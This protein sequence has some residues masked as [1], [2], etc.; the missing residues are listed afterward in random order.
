MA[1]ELIQGVPAGVVGRQSSG[2]QGG[3]FQGVESSPSLFGSPPALLDFASR[4]MGPPEASDP[5]APPQS[6]R[7]LMNPW[8]Q[9]ATAS[10]PNPASNVCVWHSSRGQEQASEAVPVASS[11]SATR[12][13]ALPPI[14]SSEQAHPQVQYHD[15]GTPRVNSP[16]VPMGQAL[17]ATVSQEGSHS[18]YKS[19]D[20]FGP[21]DVPVGQDVVSAGILPASADQHSALQPRVSTA[22]SG[23]ALQPRVSPADS[24]IALQSRAPRISVRSRPRL[25]ICRGERNRTASIA[26]RFRKSGPER[27]PHRYHAESYSTS[28]CKSRPTASVSAAFASVPSATTF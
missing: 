13:C 25:S 11:V 19:F 2:H 23:I 20:L 27:S 10:Q 26:S 21:A 8:C 17:A 1:L 4:P 16:E 7:P 12:P 24:G 22:D 9:Q 3:A 28:L 6:Y 15:I 18:S 5:Q 14:P